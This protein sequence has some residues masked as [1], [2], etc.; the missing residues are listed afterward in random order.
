MITTLTFDLDD[1]LWSVRDVIGR[2]EQHM[3]GLLEQEF[4]P[5]TQR[6]SIESFAQCRQDLLKVAPERI[7]NLRKL[8]RDALALEFARLDH[9]DPEGFADHISEAF[10]TARQQV[11]FWPGVLDTL[12]LLAQQYRI[13]AITNGTT[14]I[15]ASAAGAYFSGAY[16]ADQYQHGKPDPQMFEAAMQDHQFTPQ[17]A[18]HIGDHWREDILAAKSLGFRT[19][20]V[21]DEPA[22]GPEA[23]WALKS[24]V[25]L[26]QAL[27]QL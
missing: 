17:Q 6:H 2:A 1:T 23:D 19:A 15:L 8:R 25:Q 18:V 26:P 14:D 16:R 5:F 27:A 20:W 10:Q 12:A 3:F 24:I 21:S 11:N 22:P 4:S 9:P 13:L 7:H